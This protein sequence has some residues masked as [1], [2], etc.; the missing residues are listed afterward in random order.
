[1]WAE[2]SK[3]LSNQGLQMLVLWAWPILCHLHPSQKSRCIPVCLCL[4]QVWIW[5][6]YSWINRCPH[7]P[8]NHSK[9]YK[10][11]TKTFY[12]WFNSFFIRY[13]PQ[14][15]IEK[16]LYQY[17]HCEDMIPLRQMHVTCKFMIDDTQC[18]NFRIF[19]A[20]GFYVKSI[21]KILE[22]EDLS[23]FVSLDA[24]IITFW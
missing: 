3:D 9:T 24:L 5:N 17:V 15:L 21:L 23:F 18:G 22:V 20:L 11:F 16:T 12:D 7:S 1:M 4:G 10:S 6:W 14:D 2:T 13:E 8:G 19:Q